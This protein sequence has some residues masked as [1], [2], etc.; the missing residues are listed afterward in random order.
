MQ[1]KKYTFTYFF[2]DLSQL[3]SG[4]SQK[5]NTFFI[6]KGEEKNRVVCS[7]SNSISISIFILRKSKD[8]KSL[9]EVNNIKRGAEV[10]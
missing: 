9:Q 1:F 10:T 4:K 7:N 8:S 2:H 3:W 5:W 6:S